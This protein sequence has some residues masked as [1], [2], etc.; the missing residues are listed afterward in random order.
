MATQQRRMSRIEVLIREAV[1]PR[2]LPEDDDDDEEGTD[3]ARKSIIGDLFL[4][5]G[6]ASITRLA[7]RSLGAQP[8]VA[9][10]A[11]FGGT[12]RT[13]CAAM[14]HNVHALERL[15]EWG[16][17]AGGSADAAEVERVLS[18]RRELLRKERERK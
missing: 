13:V 14:R 7:R 10:T 17:V 9:S 3:A 1:A 12:H 6:T 4:I 18:E 5:D 16:L 15:K 8:A 11:E 2:T